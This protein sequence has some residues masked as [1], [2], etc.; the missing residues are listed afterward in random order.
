MATCRPMAIT[1][2]LTTGLQ[3]LP[4]RLLSQPM[5]ML[6]P[7]SK[8]DNVLVEWDAAL[9]AADDERLFVLPILV[10][11]RAASPALAA[12]PQ[13][14]NFRDFGAHNFDHVSLPYLTY[15][16][17]SLRDIVNG[18]LEQQV[19]PRGGISGQLPSMQ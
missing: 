10:G 3:F 14:F 7:E 1:G 8:P 12:A 9:Q 4:F 13:E 6:T 2:N 15:R 19:G 17:K 5:K 11:N 18:I 16:S